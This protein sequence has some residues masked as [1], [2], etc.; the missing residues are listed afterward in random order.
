MVALVYAAVFVI[1]FAL[2]VYR[3]GKLHK[4]KKNLITLCE[5]NKN[6]I[7]LINGEFSQFDKGDEF[8]NNGNHYADDLDIFGMGSLFQYLNRTSTI[9]GKDKLADCLAN[10]ELNPNVILQK[11]HAVKELAEIPEWRQSLQLIGKNTNEKK[12]D[13]L[14]ILKWIEE[15]PLIKKSW[16][17]YFILFINLISFSLLTLS[18]LNV[19]SPTVFILHIITVPFLIIGFYFKRINVIHAQLGRKTDLFLK[20]SSIIKHIEEKDFKSEYL[21]KI[22][23]DSLIINDS[24]SRII[25]NLSKI[26]SAFNQR[27]NM[28]AGILLNLFLLWDLIQ[29][30]RLENWKTKHKI[31]LVKWFDAVAEF[32]AL[33]SLGCFYFIILTINF[34]KLVMMRFWLLPTKWDIP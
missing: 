4:L 9:N 22:K 13:V 5:I 1:I 15:A 8:I 30:M 26:S 2:I 25:K 14:D 6:E 29:C 3:H 34:L 21:N 18:I 16:F 27:L 17:K 20:F 23:N 10:Q 24:A 31:Q 33:S 19:I 12:Q 28:I 11:Q 32:D 7:L